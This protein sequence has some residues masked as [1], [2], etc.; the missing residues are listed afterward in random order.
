ME[1]FLT[2]LDTCIKDVIRMCM[3]MKYRKKYK[4]IRNC[5]HRLKNLIDMDKHA[6][7]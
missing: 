2:F 6:H 7:T 4:D 3:V 1:I 5:R